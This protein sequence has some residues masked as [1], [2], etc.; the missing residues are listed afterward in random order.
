MISTVSTH[1]K[2]VTRKFKISYGADIVCLVDSAV[3]DPPLKYSKPQKSS[4]H[5]V[6]HGTAPTAS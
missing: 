6:L 4:I 5:T 3:T 1:F 2:V